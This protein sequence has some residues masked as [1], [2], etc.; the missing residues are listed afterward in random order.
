M[1]SGLPG[2]LKMRSMGWETSLPNII[3][4][5]VRP[6]DLQIAVRSA[7]SACG[8]TS[9]QESKLFAVKARSILFK[10]LC[11]RS[12]CPLP[13]GLYPVVLVICIPSASPTSLNSL[14]MNCCPQSECIDS[15][16]PYLAKISFSSVLTVAE[17][18][19]FGRGNASIHL[20]K[21]SRQVRIYLAPVLF[22]SLSGPTK[23][24]CRRWKG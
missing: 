13:L 19:A 4:K 15:G 7:N 14:D 21:L 18:V 10:S 16:I 9:S 5:G 12:T 3:W 17:A 2:D 23:S 1:A 24:M 11:I 20:E 8:R 6:V 22:P